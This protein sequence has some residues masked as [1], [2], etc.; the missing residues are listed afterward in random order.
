MVIR[1]KNGV[2]LKGGVLTNSLRKCTAEP[3]MTP[4]IFRFMDNVLFTLNFMNRNYEIGNELFKYFMEQTNITYL[5]CLKTK[6]LGNPLMMLYHIISQA[7]DS[8]EPVAHLRNRIK[9]DGNNIIIFD[10]MI[11]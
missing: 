9:L 5:P 6:P 2:L 1:V 11:D 4:D 10:Q 7:A 3:W 8:P